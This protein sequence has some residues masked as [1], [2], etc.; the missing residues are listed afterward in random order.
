MQMC[1]NERMSN[2]YQGRQRQNKQ[3]NLQEENKTQRRNAD[4]LAMFHYRE[5]LRY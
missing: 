2:I 5:K 4:F 1:Y 3:T